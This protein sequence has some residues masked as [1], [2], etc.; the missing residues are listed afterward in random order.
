MSGIFIGD[1]HIGMY[2]YAPETKHSDFNT[3]IAAQGLRDAID[4]LIARSPDAETGL[5][6]DV[7]DFMHMN[8]S[9]YTTLKEP[10]LIATQDIRE[11]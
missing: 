11:F 9:L 3:D 6:C 4:D 7:G 5:L 2:A 8:S 10:R 1:A